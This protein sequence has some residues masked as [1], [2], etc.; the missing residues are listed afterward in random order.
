[1][2]VKFE[3]FTTCLFNSLED[4]SLIYKTFRIGL[5]IVILNK[6]DKWLVYCFDE[7]RELEKVK[8]IPGSRGSRNW[9]HV[10][11]IWVQNKKPVKEVLAYV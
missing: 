3:K 8:V 11:D 5:A 7:H 1:V 6:K 9:E 4:A 2:P 10:Q